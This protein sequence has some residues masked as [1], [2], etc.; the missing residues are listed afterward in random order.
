MTETKS[1][2]RRAC[3]LMC[4]ACGLI[5]GGIFPKSLFLEDCACASTPANLENTVV[6]TILEE[7]SMFGF[8]AAFCTRHNALIPSLRFRR[9]SCCSRSNTL[10][11]SLFSLA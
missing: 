1:S 8:R 6:G 7:D 4:L 3:S 9:R 5:P 2:I 11:S 10:A